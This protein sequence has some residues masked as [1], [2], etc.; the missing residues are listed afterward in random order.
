MKKLK[1][2]FF[3]SLLLVF[4]TGCVGLVAQQALKNKLQMDKSILSIL[5]QDRLDVLN[6]DERE[7]V[8]M[9]KHL[10]DQLTINK[11]P[12]EYGGVLPRNDGS[13]FRLEN[14]VGSEF[15]PQSPVGL[16]CRGV[17]LKV[18]LTTGSEV[19]SGQGAVCLDT[20][21]EEP[22]WERRIGVDISPNSLKIAV[23]PKPTEEV[24]TAVEKP[25]KH[26]KARS[27]KK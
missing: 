20:L 12:T 15:S 10:T 16:R 24:V 25:T 21:D 11:A 2:V 17:R 26:K 9:E 5:G 6:M 19:V 27:K 22:V 4:Q 8:M 7:R 1:L 14:L 3:L 18:H 13:V 23:S